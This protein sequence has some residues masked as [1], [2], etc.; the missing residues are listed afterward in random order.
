MSIEQVLHFLVV[1]GVTVL[2][3]GAAA[4]FF[5][6]LTD[7]WEREPRGT[8][9]EVE[10]DMAFLRAS[11]QLDSLHEQARQAMIQRITGQ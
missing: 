6:L 5:I 10:E 3:I 1:V 9:F 11:Q 2:C 4:G 8:D 7:G